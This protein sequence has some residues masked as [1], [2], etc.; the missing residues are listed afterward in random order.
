MS[1]VSTHSFSIN[2]AKS[3]IDKEIW[4]ALGGGTLTWADNQNPPYPSLSINKFNDL[5]GL[6][7]IDVKRLVSKD[8]TGAIKTQDGSY[9]YADSFLST[10]D[11]INRQAYY[12]YVEATVQP[13]S[14]LDGQRITLLGLAENVVF[15]SGTTNI[16]KKYLYINA[17]DVLDY[18][19]S[20]V[21][22][23]PELI[24]TSEQKFQFIR[25]F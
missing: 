22:T 21:S 7:Y 25:R 10:E 17:E 19:L 1:T 8:P 24:I 20:L 3:Y 4:V 16:R 23:V 6:L 9:T 15:K 11:L 2:I 18:N 13:E 14:S 12:L 5:I